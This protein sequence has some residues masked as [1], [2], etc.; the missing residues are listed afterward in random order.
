MQSLLSTV[1]NLWKSI[2]R[3]PAEQVTSGSNQCFSSSGL[4]PEL[5][6]VQLDID[7]ASKL[8]VVRFLE[9]WK[10]EMR[11]SGYNFDFLPQVRCLMML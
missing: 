7:E 4:F 2:L 9:G 5:L 11:T 8:G 1:A 10:D 6:F 3:L